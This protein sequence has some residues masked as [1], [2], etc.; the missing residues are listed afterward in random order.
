MPKPPDKP[1][2]VRL[3]KKSQVPGP[4]DE[5]L[6]VKESGPGQSSGP[7]QLDSPGEPRQ[8]KSERGPIEYNR[9]HRPSSFAKGR[10]SS[11]SK[12]PL[13][14]KTKAHAGTA[15][16]VQSEARSSTRRATKPAPVVLTPAQQA[17]ILDLYREMVNKG[18]RPPEGRRGKIAALLNVPYAVVAQVVKGHVA[19]ARYRRTNFEIEKLYWQH[20]RRGEKNAATIAQQI[21]TQLKLELGRV[22]W[23]LEKLHQ[24]RKSF[25]QD[26]ELTEAEKTAILTAYEA[27]LQQ[28]EP[29]EK[30]LHQTL[31]E[32]VGAVTPRQVHNVLWSYR[33]QIWQT[34]EG[35]EKPPVTIPPTNAEAG[36]SSS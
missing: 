28:E 12:K 31:A 29:P 15:P 16:S 8:W 19:H 32:Q 35:R 9:P 25:A 2:V 23:W 33:N 3:I 22:W 21:A 13:G 7:S 4:A 27:Y 24:P 20:V 11:W 30:G 5:P 26:A 14:K 1:K 34:L 36:A 10:V 6:P 17:E 18:E